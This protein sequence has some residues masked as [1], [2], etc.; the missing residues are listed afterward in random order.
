MRKASAFLFSC[1][2]TLGCGTRSG[3]LEL[4]PAQDVVPHLE[5]ARSQAVVWGQ[6]KSAPALTLIH[7]S[8]LHGDAENL[9]RIAQ[10]WDAYG[11]WIEDAIHVGDVVACYWDD[12]N[13][14]DE[15]PSARSIMNV[16]GN[17]DCWKGH[18]L[19]SQTP[20]PYDATAA[21]AYELIMV[22]KDKAH[23]F[24]ADWDVV[25]PSEGLCYYFKDYDAQRVRL[26]ALDCMHYDEA[27][28]GWF[29]GLLEDAR[30]KGLTVIGAQHFPAQSGLDKIPSGFSERDEEIGPE[31]SPAADSQFERLSDE[32]FAAVDAFLDAGG[33]FACW[34]S[35]HTHL[36]FIG[37]I[38][39]HERQLQIIADKAGE[40]DDYMQEARPRGTRFQDSF[41][42]VTV[43]TG[44][45]LLVVKRIGCDRDQ[46]M[47]SKSLFCY[48]YKNGKVIVNE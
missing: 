16:V 23:P 33:S 20:R 28:H 13:P 12:P 14:W 39:G 21:D 26:I 3:I 34:L 19:W 6:G 43:N 42:L 10:F 40:K 35:G 25:S 44:R 22:G 36:D 38:S 29:I 47:R 9:A 45:S 7:F 30:E 32:A 2:L 11:D 4:N 27:Q 46:Y 1:L 31:P 48:D 17:H 24:I 41:N 18:L 8:D 15:V 5:A 37:H